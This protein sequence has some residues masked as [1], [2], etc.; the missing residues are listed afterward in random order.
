MTLTARLLSLLLGMLL[1]VLVLFSVGVYKLTD[2]F[3]H[4]EIRDRLQQSLAVLGSAVEIDDDGVE[5]DPIEHDLSALQARAGNDV[6][7]I[8]R[9]NLRVLAQSNSP[10]A[11]PLLT[12][13]L[14]LTPAPQPAPSLAQPAAGAYPGTPIGQ[15][16]SPPATAPTGSPSLAAPV[17]PALYQSA[18]QSFP[19]NGYQ[20][21]S[22]D[23][24][25]SP[26][27]TVTVLTSVAPIQDTLRQLKFVLMAVS[28]V[29]WFAVLIVGYW[30]CRRALAPITRMASLARTIN[31]D[32][33]QQRLPLQGTRDELDD[34][35]QAFN[36]MLDRLHESFDRQQRFT[37]DAS[38]QLRT[39][40]AAMLGQVEVALRRDRPAEEYRRVL[41]LVQNKAVNL[42]Q[43][44]EMLLFLSRADAEAA[45]P[46]LEPVDLQQWLPDHM[47]AWHAHHRAE[48][49]HC[50]TP[51]AGP[52]VV[53][54]QPALL[55]QLIDNLIDNACKYSNPG[56]PVSVG[57]DRIDGQVCL[58]VQ[59]E[60]V[61][62]PREE[63][64]HIFDPFY[65]SPRARQ[66]GTGGVGLGLSIVHRLVE[67]L[68]GKIAVASEL[69]HGTRF[70][71]WLP[72]I[73]GRG[74]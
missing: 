34:L 49:I 66:S 9:D 48:D 44:I 10:W 60:G 56:T 65:R 39:P 62:I 43:I 47:Q 3:L 18:Q 38:H 45:S 29:T 12:P 8:V 11:A 42:R 4:L 25:K 52:R 7:W 23:E 2:H 24:E 36:G 32:D 54:T 59:D 20:F 27:I 35:G 37:G 21:P 51:E 53:R 15:P 57:L 55:S 6:A 19:G 58:T 13:Q 64:A 63:L 73:Q 70:T 40:L 28:S 22:V 69:G 17:N 30:F 71:I 33:L 50:F 68:G 26:W 72:E 1:A 61:G 31:V 67:S 5:W 14:P 46:Q 41:E 16:G 74:W